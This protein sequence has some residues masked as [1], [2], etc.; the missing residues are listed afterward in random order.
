M[1]SIFK[2]TFVDISSTPPIYSI[3][4]QTDFVYSNMDFVNSTGNLVIPCQF[5]YKE[6]RL[7]LSETKVEWKLT[8]NGSIIWHQTFDKQQ[9][10]L[11]IRVDSVHEYKGMYQ[12]IASS[13]FYLQSLVLKTVKIAFNPITASFL[14]RK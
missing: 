3:D 2:T 7:S 5:V 4:N 1:S 11:S 13:S 9:A 14:G 10:N 8:G 12:C 6:S